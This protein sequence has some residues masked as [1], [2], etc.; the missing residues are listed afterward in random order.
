MAAT[1]ETQQAL[2]EI[3]GDY[4]HGFVTDIEMDVAPKGLNEDVVRMISAKT[5]EPVW[6]LDRRLEAFRLWRHQP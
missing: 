3:G 6:L 1:T 2:K 4:K 5:G